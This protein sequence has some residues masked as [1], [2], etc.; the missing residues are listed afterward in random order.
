[1]SKLF[2]LTTLSILSLIAIFGLF[3]NVSTEASTQYTVTAKSGLNF[4]NQNC[5]II[6][7]LRYGTKVNG[8]SGTITC[9]VNGINYKMINTADGYAAQNFLSA[10]TKPTPTTYTVNATGGLNLRD[11]G[12]NKLTTVANGTKLGK[13]DYPKPADCIISGKAY[14]LVP[15]SYNGKTYFAAKVFLK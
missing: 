10:V 5:K 13:K 14:T 9:K 15:V 8:I 11:I 2:K 4:R 3:N 1:M 6:K 7:T 12:C